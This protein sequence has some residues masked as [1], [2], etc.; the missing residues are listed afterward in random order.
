MAKNIEKTKT[1]ALLQYAPLAGVIFVISGLL[2]FLDQRLQTNWLSLSIPAF[3]GLVIS[4]YGLYKRN[5]WW[6]LP[7]LIIMGLGS[8]LITLLIPTLTID[9]VTR[10]GFSFLANSL[11]WLLVFMIIWVKSRQKAWWALFVSFVL[12]ALAILFL[13][14]QFTLLV[15]IFY[16][17]TAIGI[18][19]LL[20]GAY[21]GRISLIVPGALLIATGAGVFFGWSNP[22]TPGGLQKTGIM[23][24]WFALGWVLIT[25]FSRIMN[26]HFVWWPLIPGGILLMVGSGL[27]IGG[28]PENALGFLGNT[29]SIG[30]ILIGAYLIFLKFGMKK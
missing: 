21:S 16:L 4:G 13:T 26:K 15:F 25:V 1:E 14:N 5:H 10:L 9:M 20:W 3:I 8:A 30:L 23:L 17:S 11:A 18:V 12:A 27:Y 24:V 29:G 28:N 22:D 2:L 19:F 7:G 6:V